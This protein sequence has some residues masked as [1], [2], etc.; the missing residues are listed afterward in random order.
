MLK[1]SS[2]K[3][4]LVLMHIRSIQISVLPKPSGQ[5]R[6][7]PLATLAIARGGMFPGEGR[8]NLVAYCKQR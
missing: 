6:S 2:Q 1:L 4:V 8:Q 7:N 3:T 5:W